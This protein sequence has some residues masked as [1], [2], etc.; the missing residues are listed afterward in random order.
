MGRG[1]GRTRPGLPEVRTPARRAGAFQTCRT[2]ASSCPACG[3]VG[4]PAARGCVLI[5]SGPAAL[6]D[7]RKQL[8]YDLGTHP[9]APG[10]LDKIENPDIFRAKRREPPLL[11]GTPNAVDRV[12]QKSRCASRPGR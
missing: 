2:T 3:K 10:P 8:S 12:H 1:P 11:H 6:Q 7:N 5:L 4:A 9:R